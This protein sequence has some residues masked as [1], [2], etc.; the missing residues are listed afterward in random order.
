MASRGDHLLQGDRV[1]ATGEGW[2]ARLVAPA[3]KPLLH[4]LDERLVRGGIHGTLPDGTA[5]DIGFNAPGHV[6]IV[7]L[8]SY[9]ALVRLALAGSVGWYKAWEKNEWTSPDPVPLFALIMDN[10]LALGDTARAKGPMRWINALA[11]RLR[12]NGLVRARENI[13]AHYDLG[14]DF[15]SQWLDPTMSYSSAIFA[16]GDGL[17]AAQHRK[18]EALL[19]RL[20]LAEGDRLLEIGCGWGSLAIA[21]ARRGARVV[22]LTL[23]TEQKAW[24]DDRIAEAGL[25]DRIEIRLQD[26]RQCNEHFDAVASVEMVE[27]V[28][29]RW[30]PAYLD[31]IRRNLRPGGRAALQFI[32][33]DHRL[34]PAYRTSA[35]F[36]QTYIFPGGMLLD[37]PAFSALARER[38]LTWG[39]RH[40]FAA[41]YARTLRHWRERYDAAVARGELDG[42]SERFHDLWRFYLMYCEG[43]FAGRGIDVAQVT[44][45]RTR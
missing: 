9:M 36:I 38:G 27:A 8:H 2:L 40:G 15:Y 10:A 18:I 7:H 35:D 43:G 1:F 30:W 28:G 41:D 31:C 25:S 4:R 20:K 5:R 33:I 19:D 11:H 16:P 3:F 6:A 34:F 23:S 45:T 39:D 13:A 17:E 44:L 26:Y 29:E 12:D 22:G 42:F 24:A 14:N 32:S 37:E 21:A